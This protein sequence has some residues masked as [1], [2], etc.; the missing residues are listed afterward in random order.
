MST[1]NTPQVIRGKGTVIAPSI[2]SL[3]K[4]D[5]FKQKN[6]NEI[7]SSSYAFALEPNEIMKINIP[8]NNLNGMFYYTITCED[9]HGGLIHY[10]MQT[11]PN[12]V[13]VLIQ[14][15]TDV[16]RPNCIIHWNGVST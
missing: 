14:N 1:P 12:N 2:Q 8:V 11:T 10:I 3:G 5:N 4:K 16:N 9:I 15:E 7:N 6:I 13:S